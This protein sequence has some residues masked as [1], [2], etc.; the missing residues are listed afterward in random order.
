MY[1]SKNTLL[2][3]KPPSASLSADLIA[4]FKSLALLTIRIPFP[5]PPAAAFTNIGNPIELAFFGSEV[6]GR[7]GTFAFVAISFAVNLSPIFLIA[8]ADGPTHLIF[9]F[10][11]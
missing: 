3:P 4:S 1:L 6:I 5:P 9:N 10:L 2:S 8:F 11:T 7:V